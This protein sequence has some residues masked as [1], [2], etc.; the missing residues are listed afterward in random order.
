MHLLYIDN[1]KTEKCITLKPLQIEKTERGPNEK[2]D[3][4]FNLKESPF[5]NEHLL[6]ICRE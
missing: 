1:K 3:L 5:Q 2:L 4:L 6:S